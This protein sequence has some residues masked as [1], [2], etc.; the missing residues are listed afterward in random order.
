MRSGERM[1]VSDLD[2]SVATMSE[3]KLYPGVLFRFM[4]YCHLY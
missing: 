3:F 1:D 4:A 2:M